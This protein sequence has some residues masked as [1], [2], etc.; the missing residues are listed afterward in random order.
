[1]QENLPTT[2]G[3]DHSS[4]PVAADMLIVLCTFPDLET[5][6]RISTEIITENLAACVNLIPSVESIYRWEGK[7]EKS[8]E[9]LAIFKVSVVGFKKLEAEL[10]EMHPYETPEIIGIAA[11]QVSLGYLKWVLGPG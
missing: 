11:D 6:R 7:I 3:Q 1:M 4:P 5:A 9:V 8:N 2:G 10:L